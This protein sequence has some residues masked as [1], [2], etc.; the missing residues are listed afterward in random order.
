MRGKQV[1]CLNN[2]HKT[3]LPLIFGSMLDPVKPRY[4]QV[5]KI[6]LVA[7]HVLEQDTSIEPSTLRRL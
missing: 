5:F 3:E 1:K 6:Q 7:D 2:G 4:Q